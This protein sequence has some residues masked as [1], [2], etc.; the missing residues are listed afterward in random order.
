MNKVNSLHRRSGLEYQGPLK[1]HTTYLLAGASHQGRVWV[2][3]GLI[4]KTACP[5]QPECE[6]S[7]NPS[8]LFFLAWQTL[9][10]A[11]QAMWARAKAYCRILWCQL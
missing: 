5:Q 7:G 3:G 11:S 1:F 10:F 4:R 8:E 6:A 2:L 9:G